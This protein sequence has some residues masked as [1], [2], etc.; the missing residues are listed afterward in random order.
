[1][2][3]KLLQVPG[4]VDAEITALK[5]IDPTVTPLLEKQGKKPFFATIKIQDP[6]GPL[7]V[8]EMGDAPKTK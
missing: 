8:R 2:R 1:M 3:T 5:D 6:R 4:V 7:K